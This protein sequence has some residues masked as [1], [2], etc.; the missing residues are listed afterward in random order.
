[1]TQK[2]YESA[3]SI[4]AELIKL[5]AA[6]RKLE[7]D[8][9]ALTVLVFDDKLRDEEPYSVVINNNNNIN[10]KYSLTDYINRRIA[11][12]EKEFEEL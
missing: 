3:C 10:I 4:R 5:Q 7:S 1:M 12:L 2:Q 9:V 6:L 8:E 11:E